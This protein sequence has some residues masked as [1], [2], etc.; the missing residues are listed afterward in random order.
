[1]ETPS[2][3]YAYS[4][5]TTLYKPITLALVRVS[6]PICKL[7]YNTIDMLFSL[8]TVALRLS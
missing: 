6:Y 2:L 1:M 8:S 7:F 4:K 3:V 5:R